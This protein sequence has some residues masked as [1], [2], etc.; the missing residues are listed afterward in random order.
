MYKSNHFRLI[1]L[2]IIVCI[3]LFLLKKHPAK[4]VTVKIITIG[5]CDEYGKCGVELSDGTFDREYYP[6]INKE[7]DICR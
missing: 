4:C 2:A 3:G 7:I 5:P 1:L 6:I